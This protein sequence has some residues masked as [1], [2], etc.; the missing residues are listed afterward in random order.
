M[1]WLA[2]LVALSL[3][4]WRAARFIRD[5]ALIAGTRER[6]LDWL[7]PPLHQDAGI[8]PKLVRYKAYELLTCPYCLTVH[9][10]WISVLIVWAF[11]PIALPV[12]MMGAVAGGSMVVWRIVGI[13]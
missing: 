9:C 11:T 12:L 4:A 5:D 1:S 10:S 13:D 3:W 7:W 2:L 6:V 8:R